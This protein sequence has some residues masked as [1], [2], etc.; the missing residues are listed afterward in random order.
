MGGSRG[1]STRFWVKRLKELKI[2]SKETG[3]S[4]KE[5]EVFRTF[6]RQPPARSR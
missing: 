1:K 2:T 3:L 4:K 6:I 5:L